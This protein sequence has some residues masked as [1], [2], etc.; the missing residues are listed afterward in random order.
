MK[1]KGFKKAT[2]QLNALKYIKGILIE[3]GEVFLIKKE[4]CEITFHT[5]I[6]TFKVHEK[7]L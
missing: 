5:S 3:F 6:G 7:D 1:F 2:T 4:G